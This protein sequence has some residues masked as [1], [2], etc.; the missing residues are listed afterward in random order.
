MRKGWEGCGEYGNVNQWSNKIDEN[1]QS[2]FYSENQINVEE[3]PYWNYFQR[4]EDKF[5]IF[6]IHRIKASDE[7][8]CKGTRQKIGSVTTKFSDKILRAAFW[9]AR[10]DIL[11]CLIGIFFA[12][13]KFTFN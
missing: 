1:T 12:I 6:S 5:N 11:F 10:I 7:E 9:M 3:L 8:K 13:G 2:L 4:I